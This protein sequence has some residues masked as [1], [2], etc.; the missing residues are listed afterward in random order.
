MTITEIL[1]RLDS[2]EDDVEE[3][4]HIPPASRASILNRVDETI[5]A[6][7]E[8]QDEFGDEDISDENEY[9]DEN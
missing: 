4:T 7:S 6:L 8:A 2:I 1:E 3:L 9:D 5:A